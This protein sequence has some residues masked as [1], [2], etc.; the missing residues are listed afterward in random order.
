VVVLGLVQ[1]T[2]G[3]EEADNHPPAPG[4]EFTTQQLSWS[5]DNCSANAKKFAKMLAEVGHP[6]AP[7]E[8]AAVK[9]PKNY[10][11]RSAGTIL[12]HVTRV[13][14]KS[15]DR[16]LFNNPGGPGGAA[17]LNLLGLSLRKKELLNTHTFVGVDPRGTGGST[18]ID[19]GSFAVPHDAGDISRDSIK[20]QQ[21]L[22]RNWVRACTEKHG[23]FLPFIN[24][25]QTVRDIDLVRELLGYQ[26][27]DYIGYSGGTWLGSH[28]ATYFPARTGNFILDSNVDF[29]RSWEKNFTVQ[30][31]GFQRRFEQQFLAWLARHP[32]KWNFGTTAADAEKNYEKI[33]QAI[34][35]GAFAPMSPTGLD[36]AIINA[37]YNKNTFE[38]V[39]GPLA[40]ALKVVVNAPGAPTANAVVARFKELESADEAFPNPS[41]AAVFTA[42]TCNDTEWNK[43]EQYWVRKGRELAREYPLAGAGSVAQACVYWPYQATPAIEHPDEDLK[44]MLL[45]QA[46]ADPA[47]PWELGKNA[48]DKA[49]NT[50]FLGVNDE[51][52]HGVWALTGNKCVDAIGDKYLLTG[53]LPE[54]DP[55]CDGLPLPDETQLY[56]ID[57]DSRAVTEAAPAGH[58]AFDDFDVTVNGVRTSF[59]LLLHRLATPAH[60]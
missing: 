25:E 13:K 19:C 5:S 59:D 27:F 23:D 16:A 31:V 20:A 10:Y 6:L 42:V 43:S 53:E 45:I 28:Y 49:R 35:L 55:V 52:D 22:Q 40:D 30:P 57:P 11:D 47:T 51:G 50:V 60:R 24:T 44:K 32:D 33:R 39:A 9:A 26:K 58:R 48:H 37:L 17:D 14:G 56:P 7:F 18:P 2:A 54:K 29:T 21:D 3:A 38:L 36:L 46:E 8:C 4:N 12:V 15:D 1:A 34:A 41:L